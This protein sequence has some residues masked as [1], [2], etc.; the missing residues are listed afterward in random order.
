MKNRVSANERS[1]KRSNGSLSSANAE[2]RIPIRGNCNGCA[3][4]RARKCPLHCE[5]D[6]GRAPAPEGGTKG[7]W[8]RVREGAGG[9]SWALMF[10]R[11]PP[12]VPA[13]QNRACERL[14]RTNRAGRAATVNVRGGGCLA[15][16]GDADLAAVLEDGAGG[17]LWESAGADVF[18]EG[19][20]QAVDVDPV[21]PGELL[22]QL[23]ER[24]FGGRGLD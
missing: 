7:G 8:G 16:L 12:P 9:K 19:D 6:K 24:L 1:R 17:A 14:T 10:S 15:V 2:I 23:E 11:P 3:E 13:F 5:T 4:R 20:Q 18:A 22:L 21:V